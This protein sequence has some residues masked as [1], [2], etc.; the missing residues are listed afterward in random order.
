MKINYLS[1]R[2]KGDKNYRIANKRIM[3]FTFTQSLIQ[4]ALRHWSQFFWECFSILFRNNRWIKIRYILLSSTKCEKIL[5]QSY[6]GFFEYKIDLCQEMHVNLLLL[7]LPALF[8][9]TLLSVSV[10]VV[11]K[12][13]MCFCKIR[14]ARVE[15]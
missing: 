5:A 6:R 7:L 10:I 3:W 11:R 13:A 9:H 4:G 15:N 2:A 1:F 12:V 8:E 14:L